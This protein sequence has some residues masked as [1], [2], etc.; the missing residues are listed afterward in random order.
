MPLAA[1]QRVPFRNDIPVAP[2][3][4]QGAAAARAARALRD[5]RRAEHRGHRASR[6]GWS[7]PWSLAFVATDTMLVTRARRRDTRHSRRQARSGAG[8][9]SAA[10]CAAEGLAGL[11]D[12]AL[13]P[14]FASNGYVYLSATAKPISADDAAVA[15]ARGRWDG[16][17]AARH[18]RRVRRRRRDGRRSRAWHSAATACS[19]VG[20][21]R[22][23]TAPARS[24]QPRRQGAAAHAR[25]QGTGRQSVRRS[26]GL[27]ARNF[28]LGHRSTLGLAA[29]PTTG[30]DLADRDGPERRRRAQRP[31]ARRQLRLAARQLRAHVS[32]PAAVA[33]LS[34]RRLHRSRRVLGAVDLDLGARVLHG[35][36]LPKWRGDIF[37]GGMR[38][39][40]IPNTGRLERMLVNE[41]MEELRRE[42]LLVDLRQ[43]IRDVRQGPDG[44]LYLLTDYEDGAL[45]RIAAVP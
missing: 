12:I 27:Q 1:Q 5:G 3:G 25:R 11:M 18:A 24:V 38:Y 13:H 34:R 14:D 4:L 17:R 44:F 22:R 26:R 29:H 6:A 40:E 23:R 33:A 42:P 41:N 19:N 36:R 20:R 2:Q 35:R 32:R 10:K 21:R 37:V 31:R 15:V 8:G 9:R 28:T 43:R 30:R 39:G 7:R 16:T 45:L